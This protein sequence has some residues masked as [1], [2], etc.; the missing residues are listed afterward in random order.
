[1]TLSEHLTELRRRLILSILA[2]CACGIVAFVFY[3]SILH[4]F[5]LPYC[6]T[7]PKSQPCKLYVQ[8]PLDGLSLRLKIAGYGGLVLAL[9]V[10]LWELWR[11]ITPGLHPREKRYSV[12]FILAS[13]LFFGLGGFA[14]WF[15]FPHALRF[16]QSIGGPSLQA[17]YSPA[18]YL[19]LIILLMVVFGVAF[20]FPVLLVALQVARVVTPAR[21]ASWRRWA[22]V[23]IFAFAAI[24]TPSSDPFSML[25][26][27]VPM[28]L[29][30]EGSIL[31]GRILK[32]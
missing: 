16:L 12:P 30:Y 20:E 21:L 9:P 27:A 32:R 1:M 19:R 28:C 29:F 5:E 23:L 22:I 17:I 2:V 7:L 14:A 10:V 13:L 15:T 4:W 3:A 24:V 25:A 8:G 18:N 11:F 26:M 6:Q 31:V